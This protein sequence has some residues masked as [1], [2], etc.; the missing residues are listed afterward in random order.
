MVK[1]R[2]IE[3][4]EGIQGEFDVIVYDRMLRRLRDRGWIETAELLKAGITGGVALEIGPGPGYLGLDWLARTEET[5]LVGLEISANMIALA[6]R[7]AQ[8]AG[9][10][11]RVRYVHGDACKMPF[12]DGTFDAVFTKRVSARMGRAA[13]DLQRNF[14]RSEGRRPLLH[15]RS[16][17]GHESASER[18]DVGFHSS[19]SDARGTDL[20]DW[21]CLR[22]AGTARIGGAVRTRPP[23]DQEEP[24][25]A[26]RD[27]QE[28]VLLEKGTAMDYPATSP[29]NIE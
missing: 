17:Q 24:A 28:R 20:F 5:S 11:E 23:R 19:Q 8:E 14:A 29:R 6:E 16:A 7:N 4:T 26:C 27:R 13:G 12:D 2:A 21:R 9:L 15:L 18:P 25:R 1:P 22:R 3:T 10:S